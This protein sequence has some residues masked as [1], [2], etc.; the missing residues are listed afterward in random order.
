MDREES[1]VSAETASRVAE[2]A[3]A[4][5]AARRQTVEELAAAMT[6]PHVGPSRSADIRLPERLRTRYRERERQLHAPSLDGISIPPSLDPQDFFEDIPP[7]SNA[8]SHEPAGPN[9]TR[10]EFINALEDLIHTSENMGT[11]RD[12]ARGLAGM[13]QGQQP[14]MHQRFY[15]AE[16]DPIVIHTGPQKFEDRDDMPWEE[17][18]N[19]LNAATIGRSEKI[20]ISMLQAS[21]GKGPLGWYNVQDM[22][23]KPYDE[24][25]RIFREAFSKRDP[26]GRKEKPSIIVM[27][28]G[29]TVHE[30][31]TRIRRHF[32]HLSPLIPNITDRDSLRDRIQKQLDYKFEC[33]EHDAEMLDMFTKG[34]PPHYHRKLL[35]KHNAPATLADAVK[36]VQEWFRVDQRVKRAETEFALQQTRQH[37]QDMVTT[38]L[39]VDEEESKNDQSSDEEDDE[40]KNA[41]VAAAELLLKSRKPEYRRLKNPVAEKSEQAKKEEVRKLIQKK[42]ADKEAKDVTKQLKGLQTL[43]SSIDKKT[44]KIEGDN[45]KLTDKMKEML[46]TNAKPKAKAGTKGD[47]SPADAEREAKKRV[48]CSFCGRFG[49]WTAECRRRETGNSNGKPKKP[50]Q[51]REKTKPQKSQKDDKKVSWRDK[52]P[53]NKKDDDKGWKKDVSKNMAAIGDTLAIVAEGAKASNKILTALVTSAE[54]KN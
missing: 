37:N 14:R 26:K 31:Q 34:L 47:P 46:T 53:D 5:A 51:G 45:K 40:E 49:H 25:M 42:K 22:R 12:L 48:Q 27:K 44:A 35:L 30:F 20:K 9:A 50:V 7:P 23:Y 24:Q 18:E 28:P 33:R 16:D 38:Y 3:E 4:T 43:L 8:E 1:I 10:A 29:E 15:S 32:M 39:A 54:S 36:M 19:S 2:E 13:V 17:F 21:L 41:F 11:Q 52:K 6:T